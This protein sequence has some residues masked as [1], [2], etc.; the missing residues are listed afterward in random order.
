MKNLIVLWPIW[1]NCKLLSIAIDFIL[2][3]SHITSISHD[4][5]S[6]KLVSIYSTRLTSMGTIV[7]YIGVI[8]L[9]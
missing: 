9:I 6:F 7:K 3:I 8:N 5:P 2:G 4:F 1:F